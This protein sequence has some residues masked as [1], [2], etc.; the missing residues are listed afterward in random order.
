ME[1]N[2]N[3][4]MLHEDIENIR[5]IRPGELI[6]ER[7]S[8]RE[9]RVI[10]SILI[11]RQKGF[12]LLKKSSLM[13]KGNHNDTEEGEEIWVVVNR[14]DDQGYVWLSREKARYRGLELTLKR[15]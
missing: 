5:P 15:A 9:K 6:K 8:K 10:L 4:E 13:V 1:E 3:L 7:L 2:K 11:I 12:F 14:F